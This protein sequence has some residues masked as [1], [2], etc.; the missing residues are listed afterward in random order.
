M[1]P[2]GS[3]YSKSTGSE[4]MYSCTYSTCRCYEWK[5]DFVYQRD[6]TCSFSTVVSC[7]QT[8]EAHQSY[9]LGRSDMMGWGGWGVYMYM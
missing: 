8:D 7:K 6:M 5:P 1:D 2:C 4:Y 9:D 3:P